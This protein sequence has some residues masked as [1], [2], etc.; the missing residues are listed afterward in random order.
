MPMTFFNGIWYLNHEDSGIM[1]CGWV[2][3]VSV[4]EFTKVARGL[5][6]L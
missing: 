2:Y 5:S 4:P 1:A 3:L 6:V